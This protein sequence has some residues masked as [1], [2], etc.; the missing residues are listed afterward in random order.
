VANNENY[1]KSPDKGLEK[2]LQVCEWERMGPGLWEK[3]RSRLMVDNVGLFLYRLLAG[4]WVR[5]AGLSHDLIQVSH[6]R[7]RV[8]Y[9]QDF[10]INL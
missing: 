10:K 6:L 4:A 8:I 5:S 9:F 3:G 7:E 1:Q 2:V